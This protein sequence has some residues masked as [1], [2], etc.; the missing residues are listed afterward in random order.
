MRVYRIAVEAVKVRS[1]L[2]RE[3]QALSVRSLLAKGFEGLHNETG[4]SAFRVDERTSG[5]NEHVEQVRFAHFE[6]GEFFIGDFG[7][8]HGVFIPNA[9]VFL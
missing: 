1:D 9:S 7:N 6:R 4:T 2:E 3:L 8:D 5:G